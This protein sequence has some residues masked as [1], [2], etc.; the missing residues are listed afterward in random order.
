MAWGTW[1]AWID[2]VGLRTLNGEIE[3]VAYRTALGTVRAEREADAETKAER[4]ARRRGL[5]GSVVVFRVEELR[6]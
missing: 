4:L 2:S 3:S 5:T 6:R 1:E